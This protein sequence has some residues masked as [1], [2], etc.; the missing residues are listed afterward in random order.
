M[1]GPLSGIRVIEMGGIGPGPFAGMLLADSG[2]D[3]IRIDRPGAN[4]ADYNN[5]V[6]SRRRTTIDLK[7]AEG[8]ERVKDLVVDADVIIDVFRPG[9]MERL[10]IGPDALHAINPRLV[11]GRMT[12]WGQT[13]PY[14]KSAGHDINYISLSGALHAI[15]R[16]SDRPV[17]PPALVGDF[18]GGAMLLAFSIC[19]ALLHVRNTGQGQVIDCAMTEGSGLLMTPFY[20]QHAVGIWTDE[21]GAN[22]I[23]SAAH[24]YDVYETSDGLYISIG[25]IE[26]QFYKLMRELMDLSDPAY[27]AHLD[28][29][30]WPSLK[31]KIIVLFKTRTRAQWCELLEKTDVCFAPVL[32]M[33]EAPLHEHGKARGSFVT[34]EGVVQPAPA[35]RYSVTTL[36]LPRACTHVDADQISWE[37]R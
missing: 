5:L 20:E 8:L 7:S 23:D 4:P 1:S 16:S 18:G 29:A 34:V 12:G 32:S 9:A 15:G 28:R 3:V 14:A 2:A 10:G 21:R 35:P 17:A 19:A 27:D 6:R 36:D 33:R 31:E 11:Y 13:G 37:G 22:I 26:P 24:F 25:A 30:A